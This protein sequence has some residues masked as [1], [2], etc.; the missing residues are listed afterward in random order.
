M[1][2]P[3]EANSFSFLASQRR[4]RIMQLRRFPEPT[5]RLASR[6]GGLK[7][8]PTVISMAGGSGER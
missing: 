7:C 5:E 4:H 8:R 6:S 1:H 2:N 3:G